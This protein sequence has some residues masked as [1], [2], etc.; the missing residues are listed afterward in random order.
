MNGKGVETIAPRGSSGQSPTERSW[1]TAACTDDPFDPGWGVEL[2]Y[3][4]APGAWGRGYATEMSRACLRLVESER[5][6]EEI[7][8]FAHP[9]NLAS[10]AVLDRIG[11]Q[12]ERYVPEMERYFYRWRPAG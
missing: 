11:F 10:Q 3:F 6:W 8:A 1:D 5:R 7:G 4:F 12:R 9:E 2:A